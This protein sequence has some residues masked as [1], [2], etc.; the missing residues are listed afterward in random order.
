MRFGRNTVIVLIL[1]VLALVVPF[2]S[3]N[4]FLR[5]F[6]T[7]L[8][9]GVLASSW[10]IIGGYTGYASFGN[11]VF[12]GIGAYVAAV[13]MEKFGLSFAIALPAAGFGA[14]LFGVLIGIPVLRLRGHYFAIATLG[15]AEAMKALVDNLEITEGNSGI[16]LPMMD[17]PVKAQYLFFYFSMLLLLILTLGV[18]FW[19]LKSKFGYGIRAIREDEDAANMVGINT[20]TFK[21]WAFALSGLFTGLAGALAAFQQGFIKPEAVFSVEITVKMIVMAVFGGIGQ[22]FGPLLGAATIEVISEFLSNYFLVAHTLF[23]GAIVILAIIFTP[24]GIIQLVSGE[25]RLNKSFFLENI[26][27]H[28]I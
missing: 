8:M 7:V 14:A 4:F 21:I 19:I 23:F 11:V 16:Y 3:N 17:M 22:L 24:K 13:L 1:F 27:E 20:T 12:Y 5:F 10:N 28:K 2:F 6:T 26:R 18:T 9:F 15:V 25:K